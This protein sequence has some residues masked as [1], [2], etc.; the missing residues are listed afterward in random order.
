MMN[1]SKMY[2]KVF[3]TKEQMERYGYKVRQNPD[4]A[5]VYTGNRDEGYTVMWQYKRTK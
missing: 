5:A 4:I 3:A 1:R 2:K